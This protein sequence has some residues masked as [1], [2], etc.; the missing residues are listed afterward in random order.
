MV[1]KRAVGARERSGVERI[2]SERE[3]GM[4][5]QSEGTRREDRDA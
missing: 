4:R 1:K 2:R 3:R 5:Q